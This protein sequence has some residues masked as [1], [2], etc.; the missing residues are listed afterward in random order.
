MPLTQLKP[1]APPSLGANPPR[2]VDPNE[3]AAKLVASRRGVAQFRKRERK[4]DN[5]GKYTA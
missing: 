2:E 5:V 1:V 3:P 4:R